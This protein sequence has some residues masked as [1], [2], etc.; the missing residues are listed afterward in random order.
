VATGKLWLGIVLLLIL[1]LFPI[2]FVLAGALEGN[3]DAIMGGLTWQ[4]FAFS[5]WEEFICV[6]M[7][8][9]LL[10]W[11]R[12]KFNR[13][14]ALAKAMSDSTFTVYFIHAP[15]LIFLALAL[16]DVDMYPLLKW[17]LVS[18]VAIFLC[19]VI[20]YYLRRLPLLKHIF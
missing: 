15:V 13:Q 6:G 20:A 2:L 4:S 17:A 16:K 5:V 14:N 3:F 7:I 8:I 1:V 9:V 10:V 11:F 12:E 19:F 18:P